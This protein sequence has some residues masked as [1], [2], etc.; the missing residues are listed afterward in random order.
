MTSYKGGRRLAKSSP[1][2][3][4]SLI[5]TRFDTILLVSPTSSPEIWAQIPGNMMTRMN[6]PNASRKMAIRGVFEFVPILSDP[7]DSALPALG[8]GSGQ[9]LSFGEI[10]PD[11]DILSL[12]GLSGGW[13]H[14]ACITLSVSNCFSGPQLADCLTLVPSD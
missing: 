13:S 10:H 6:T 2:Q 12:L 7:L 3:Y 11:I 9:V 4:R 5:G 14:I 1:F 8:S